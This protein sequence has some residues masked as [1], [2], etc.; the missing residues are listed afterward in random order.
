MRITLHLPYSI[1]WC[2]YK[3]VFGKRCPVKRCSGKKSF[4]KKV[5]NKLLL[6]RT[7][8][9]KYTSFF[10]ASKPFK[11]FYCALF[12]RRF[13]TGCIFVVSPIFYLVNLFFSLGFDYDPTEYLWKNRKIKKYMIIFGIQ[14]K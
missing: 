14:K 1:F 6:K 11:H 4:G 7:P 9:C 8:F 12:S 5:S 2:S 3:N 13:F 10:E